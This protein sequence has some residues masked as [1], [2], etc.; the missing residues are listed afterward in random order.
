LVQAVKACALGCELQPIIDLETGKTASFEVLA[1]LI[2]VQG[3][4]LSPA[5]FMPVAEERGLVHAIGMLMLRQACSFVQLQGG[6]RGPV[7]FNVNLS[8]HQLLREDLVRD[9][10][11]W[12]R[13]MDVSPANICFEVPDT[14][15]LDMNGLSESTLSLLKSEGFHLA[16]DDFG[17]G[18]I[19]FAHLR[20]LPFDF[21]KLDRSFTARLPGDESM[22]TLFRSIVAIAKGLGM[23]VT[24]K[25]IETQEQ[26][27]FAREGGCVQGQGGF[28]S[29]PLSP[30]T[31]LFMWSEAIRQQPVDVEQQEPLV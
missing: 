16:L 29:M 23:Q 5:E 2:G 22:Q 13:S 9:V 8:A 27:D 15:L 6:R 11:S 31:A 28:W 25:G 20:K 18:H 1:R 17:A 26:L 12:V 24:V 30:A 7:M 4:D 21:V 14:A 3:E 10:M 19:S